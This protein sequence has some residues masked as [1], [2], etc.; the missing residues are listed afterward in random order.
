MVVDGT[1]NQR[2]EVVHDLDGELANSKVEPLHAEYDTL[3][4]TRK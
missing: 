1:Y 4:G 3:P 2:L